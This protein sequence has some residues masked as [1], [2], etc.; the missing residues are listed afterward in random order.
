MRLVERKGT[1]DGFEW[2]CRVQSK[3]NPQFVCR[4][5]G[6]EKNEELRPENLVGKRTPLLQKTNKINTK[7]FKNYCA[8]RRL[9]KPTVDRFFVSICQSYQKK[10][11]KQRLEET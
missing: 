9:L 11:P 10:V 8:G 6:E 7:T 2:R 5:F 4:S 3:E 1:I